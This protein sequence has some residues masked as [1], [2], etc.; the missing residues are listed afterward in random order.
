ME[1][2][3]RALRNLLVSP[4]GK[5]CGESILEAIQR[6]EEYVITM[7]DGTVV[8][9]KDRAAAA[10]MLQERFGWRLVA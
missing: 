5:N 8:T 3:E 1:L 6:G 4:Y 2:T 7:D 9:L 10:H